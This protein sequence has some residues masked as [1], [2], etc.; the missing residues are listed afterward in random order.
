[1]EP[2]ADNN[3]KSIATRDRRLCNPV[4]TIVLAH[5]VRRFNPDEFGDLPA[6]EERYALDDI[7]REEIE[8]ILYVGY[9]DAINYHLD[10]Q[11]PCAWYTPSTSEVS[12]CLDHAGC[13]DLDEVNRLIADDLAGWI[14][15]NSGPVR[16][17]RERIELLAVPEY[18]PTA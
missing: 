5:E 9:V 6:I 15:R 17:A 16:E 18:L 11:A 7:S 8:Y 2:Q 10:K 13:I 4:K 14:T 1:M 12:V 3:S